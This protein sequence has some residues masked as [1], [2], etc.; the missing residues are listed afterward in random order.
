MP[1]QYEIH[2]YQIIV[3][4]I[5]TIDN[6]EIR[7]LNNDFRAKDTPTDVLSF[8]SGEY[9]SEEKEIFLGDIIISLERAAEQSAEY[10]NTLYEE[11]AFLT[12]HSVLHLLGYDH[13]TDAEAK[14][15]FAKQDAV[16]T[17]LGLTRKTD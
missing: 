6:E 5:E 11:V 8:P 3:D 14:I 13:M 7:N 1:T 16:M 9:P 10:G 15:M 2:E 12:S 4:F 17:M